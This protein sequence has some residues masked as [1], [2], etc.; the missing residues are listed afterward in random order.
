MMAIHRMKFM[1]GHV[2]SDLY[3]LTVKA[4]IDSCAEMRSEA[5]EDAKTWEDG[6]YM[7]ENGVFIRDREKT[8]RMLHEKGQRLRAEQDAN[9][10]RLIEARSAGVARGP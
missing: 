2:Q 7:D 9:R 3:E 8:R 6:A 5:R 4:Y 10:R 1:G